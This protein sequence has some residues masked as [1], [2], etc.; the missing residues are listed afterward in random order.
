MK[1]QLLAIIFLASGMSLLAQTPRLSLVEEFTGE[2]CP[3]CAANNPA[4]NNLLALPT[5]TSKVVPLKWQV[6][7]PSAPSATW[8]LYQTNKVE[9]D[10][11]WQT[12][13]Y[14]INSAPSVRID[15]Q[16]PTVFGAAGQNITQMNSTVFSTAQS[17][18]SAF[19]VTLNRSWDPTYSTITVTVDIAATASFTPVGN[20]V[21]RLVMTEDKIQFATQPG[22]NGETKFEHVAIRS[23][24]SLQ[25]GTPLTAG[26]WT[27]GQTQQMVITCQ[28]PTYV[29]DKGE[30]AFVGFIQDD[31]NRQV[32]Q[33]VRSSKQPFPNDAKAMSAY[34]GSY[35]TCGNSAAPSVVVLNNGSNAITNLTVTPTVDGI[36]APATTWSG[37]LAVGATFTLPL[38]TVSTSIG[39][40]HSYNLNITG[41]SGTDFNLS[42]NLT[43][44]SFYTATNYT[45]TPVAEGFTTAAFPPTRWGFFNANN[46]ASWSRFTGAGGYALSNNSAKYDFY[47]NSVSGDAD[48]LFL[49]PMDLSG[50]TT[51]LLTFD[52]AYRQYA[53]TGAN[54]N[55]KLEVFISD[56]CG[57]TWTSAYSKSGASL[58][59]VAGALTSAFVPSIAAQWKTDT[60]SLASYNWGT[61]LVKFTA[62]SSFGNNLYIDNVNL[63][64]LDPPI[65]LPNAINDLKNNNVNLSIFPNPTNGET[66]L[67]IESNGSTAAKITVLNI[68]GQDVYSVPVNLNAGINTILINA[69]DFAPG[70][71]N[72]LI[73]SKNGTAASKLN[74]TK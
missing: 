48:D 67:R 23:F 68:L 45:S 33:A 34:V 38:N 72:V 32:A 17:F 52:R 16:M 53:L 64:Q 14:G 63:R 28:V 74:V 42:N 26:T 50:Q 71:Y 40:G 9:I 7:I 54:A 58:A 8:S 19:S 41:V 70:V 65:V 55:D 1:K 69:A 49:P 51:P 44:T 73:D 66:N 60:V 3:P 39:G 31:G 47:S 59:T 6:P 10:W 46:G 56:D 25:N 57:V 35:F 37:N 61:I 4:F 21:F 11:R 43:N 30:I 12:Y 18:T 24:P 62:T 5:N 22:T 36:I 20:L 15:G 27:N 13:G 2:T 29:R